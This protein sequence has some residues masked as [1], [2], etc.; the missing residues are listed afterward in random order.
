MDIC[1]QQAPPSVEV[2]TGHSA[3]CW[4]HVEPAKRRLDGAVIP[5]NATPANAT[6]SSTPE[7]D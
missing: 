1:S 6:L 4:L 3:A 2:G 5:A 7:E